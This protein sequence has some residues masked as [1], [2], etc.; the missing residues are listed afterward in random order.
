[1]NTDLIKVV[2]VDYI[3]DYIVD[4]KYSN[5]EKKRVDFFPLLK[6]GKK[7][8][9]LNKNNFILFGLNHWTL[10][11]YNGVDFAPDFLY[12]QGVSVS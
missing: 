3:K 6:S 10:E 9:L 11:W 2:N 1:M 4:L 5:G 7:Q 8:E 12:Q